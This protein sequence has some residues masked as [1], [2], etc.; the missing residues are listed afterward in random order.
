MNKDGFKSIFHD[1]NK[2][3]AKDGGFAPDWATEDM[4]ANRAFVLA[5]C[6]HD[7]R[8]LEWSDKSLRK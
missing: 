1:Q 5:A 8:A 2:D 3:P 4:R 7:A 6:R